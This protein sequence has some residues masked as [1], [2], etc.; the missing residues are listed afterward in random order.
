MFTLRLP[1]VLRGLACGVALLAAWPGVAAAFEVIFTFT[2]T[3]GGGHPTFPP[4]ADSMGNLY[5]TTESGGKHPAGCSQGCGTIYKLVPPSSSGAAWT[6][7]TLYSFTNGATGANPGS[8]LIA[9]GVGNYYGTAQVGG[10]SGTSACPQGC[11]T[12]YR[13]SPP[14]KGQTKWTYTVLYAFNGTTDG[15]LPFG[16]I[17]FDGKGNL[18]GTTQFQGESCMQSAGC[19]TAYKL[20]PP[21]AGKTAWTYTVIHHFTGNDGKTPDGQ[22]PFGGL[23]IDANGTLYGTTIYGG[24]YQA[25]TYGCGTVFE[26]TPPSKSGGKW[27]ED[28]LFSFD[29]KNGYGPEAPVSLENGMIFGT[30]SFGGGGSGLV[31]SLS[32]PT[33]GSGAWSE[34]ILYKFG[35]THDGVVDGA[36]PIAGLYFDQS[37][38]ILGDTGF[39][40]G[41]PCA[42]KQYPAG[43]GT[44]FQLTPPAAV[45]GKWTETVLHAFNGTT[46]GAVPTSSIVSNGAGALFSAASRGGQSGSSNS[47]NPLSV[48]HGFGTAFSV[49]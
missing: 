12:I 8:G 38:D 3:S 1:P 5:G 18:Y 41:G 39:G 9:D 47:V 14:A 4:V 32:P 33:S 45:G 26:L 24:D 2:G 15:G 31:F 44:I 36:F 30:T 7:K 42:Y 19:G 49:Q 29:R 13:L 16:A 27:T 10:I 40:G 34:A 48:H 20:A 37:G 46:D 11:G 35:G 43:C 23:T 28:I 25:C 6:E 22:E 17:V 21:A